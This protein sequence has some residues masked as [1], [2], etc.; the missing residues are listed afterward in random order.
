MAAV[1]GVVATFGTPIGGILFSIEVTATHYM[2]SHS[3]KG[4]TSVHYG[5]HKYPLDLPNL[6]AV[7]PLSTTCLLSNP[8]PLRTKPAANPHLR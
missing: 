7:K 4:S 5:I 6:P 2:V 3:W 8:Y 1:T